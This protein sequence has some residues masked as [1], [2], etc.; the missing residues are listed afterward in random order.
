MRLILL[1][2]ALLW[3]ARADHAARVWIDGRLCYL[4]R[5][6]NVVSCSEP[7]DRFGNEYKQSVPTDRFGNREDGRV[8]H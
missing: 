1:A 4:D 6:G 5:F 3:L 2:S 8:F 7:T